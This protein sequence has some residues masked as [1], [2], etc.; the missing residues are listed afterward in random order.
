M[1]RAIAAFEVRYLLRNPLVWVTAA[2]SFGAFA[3]STSLPGFE[4]GSEGGL[5][6]NSSHAVMRNLMMLSIIYMTVL[7]AFV[8]SAVTRDDE[9]GFAPII[10]TTR[11]SKLDYLLGRYFGAISVVAGCLLLGAF[12]L[13]AGTLMPWASLVENGPNRIAPYL[14][15]V[16]VVALPNLF[17]GGAVLYSLAALTRSMM[18]TYLGVIGFVSVFLIIESSLGELPDLQTALTL[19]DPFAFRAMEDATRYW[20]DIQRNVLVPEL[21]PMF[22]ANRVIWLAIAGGILAFACARYRFSDQGRSAAKKSKLL[23]EQESLSEQLK[24]PA[25]SA[26]PSPN[27][28][29]GNAWRLLWMRTRF[30]TWQ[31]LSTPAFPVLLAWGMLTTIISLTLFRNPTARPTYPTTLSLIPELEYGLVAVPILV[32]IYFA[33]ELV[34]RERD[35]RVHEIVDASPMPSWAYVLP[36]TAAMSLVLVGIT[37][38]AVLAAIILQL[39][40]GYTALEIWK[41][42]LWFMLPMSWDMMLLAAI[43]VFVHAVSPHKAVA[44]GVMLLVTM[45]YQMFPIV[46]HNLLVYGGHPNVPLSDLA[47]AGSFWIA[48]WTYRLYWA[49]F[50]TL[51]LVV[52]HVLWRRGVDVGLRSR[53]ARAGQSLRGAPARVAAV[54]SI[55]FVGFGGVAYYN[56]NILG[57]YRTEAEEIAGQ[58]DYERQYERY[59]SA[60]QPSMSHLQ[61][62]VALYPEERRAEVSGRIR[63]RNRTSVPIS[64]LHVRLI[65]PELTLLELDVADAELASNDHRHRHRIYR[66]ADPM[67][68]GEE[69]ELSYRAQRWVRGFRNK[70]PETHLIENGSF[71]YAAMLGPVVGVNRDGL[72]Q[73]PQERAKYGLPELPSLPALGDSAAR[74]I[75]DG[76]QSWATS[77]ITVSTSADQTPIAI[78][79]RVSDV[80]EDGRRRARFVSAVPTRSRFVVLSARYAERKRMHKGVE[81]AVYYHPAHEWNVDRMLDAAAQSLDYHQEAFGPYQFDHFRIVE[82]PGY[83]GFAQ[84]FGGTIPYSEAVGFIADHTRPGAIDE[85]TGM[86]AHEFAHQ[87]WAHQVVAAE[88]EGKGVLSETMAQYAAHMVMKRQRGPD[89]VR[90][91]LRFALDRYLDARQDDDPPLLRASSGQSLLY[92]KGSLAMHLLQE[93]LGEAAVNRALR[94]LVQRFGLKD[95]PY[96][97]SADLVAALRAEATTPEQQ[98]LI[99]DLWERV[100]LYDLAV[101]EPTAVQ[102][103]DGRWDVSMTVQAK[104]VYVDSTGAETEAELA[105]EI[106]VGLFAAEPG[107]DAFEA[108]DVL[109]MERRMIRS[110]S[111]V[112]TFITATKPSFAGVDPY[113]YYIDRRSFDNVRGVK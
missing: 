105:E 101:D 3:A 11:I 66:F 50:A 15:G 55:A 109:L 60:P 7:A 5:L 102:R 17:I 82:L 28:E 54:A 42:V 96:A 95:G 29:G 9:S 23:E 100:T 74:M 4:L 70:A 112:L 25:R 44:W 45:L 1:L 98:A 57:G 8:S 14:F 21:S 19:A 26:L 31:V 49:S 108:S 56:T 97:T 78:G 104:K 88:V 46:Q 65:D 89:Q 93:R 69:R 81:L 58:V 68:P 59:F 32:A 33:G 13:Y 36:K 80:T 64:E 53:V 84:A 30:E 106:E 2:L 12:G 99:T 38:V 83:Y 111:Q 39:S 85:V 63:V 113:H 75:P 62:D 86:T 51:L 41:Y 43:A 94:S 67:A 6:R 48:A 61:M 20:T 73:D 79:N 87:W 22:I 103:A 91:Y 34:W 90:R 18:G 35:R 71:L 110:G 92:R 52:A 107:S 27:H 47:D 16:L 72:L 24:P 76:N 40:L 77:D 37:A 10:R